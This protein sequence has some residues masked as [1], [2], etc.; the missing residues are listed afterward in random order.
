MLTRLHTDELKLLVTEPGV[1]VG[2]FPIKLKKSQVHLFYC[3]EGQPIFQF[4]EQY[5][6]PLPAGSYFT[7]YDQ[8]RDLD[9]TLL[10]ADCKLIYVAM[11]PEFIHEALIDDRKTLVKTGFNGFGV[12]DYS[13]HQ[14][15]FNTDLVLDSLFEPNEPNLL[16]TAYYKGK[17]LELLSYSFDIEEAHLYEAC[18]FLKEK[19]N[20]ERIKNARN[21]L[22]DNLDSPPSLGEL[23]KAIGMNEYNLK[24][25]F[26]NVYGLPAFK[27]LQEHRLGLAKKLLGEGQL[28]VSEI[29]DR[30]GYK[31]SSHFIEAFR[32]KYGN[33]PKKF[34]QAN[35]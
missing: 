28:Q 21:I 1:T 30:V 17:L 27:Y 24:V 16:K 31:S 22:I 19:E 23:A 11:P 10:C 20:V 14:I 4:S 12:R 13:I 9:L 18:P 8:G 33:T 7:I 6:R 2:P 25:G 29:A 3:R 5:Q 35:S 34:M 15:S 26:K 32:K